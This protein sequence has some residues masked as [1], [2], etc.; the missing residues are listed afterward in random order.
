M[1][2]RGLSASTTIALEIFPQ[3]LFSEISTSSDDGPRVSDL[4]QE[5]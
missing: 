3:M 4:V 5:K 2:I 1:D